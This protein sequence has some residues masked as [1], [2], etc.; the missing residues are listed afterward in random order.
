MYLKDSVTERKGETE[1]ETDLTS[2]DSQPSKG[3]ANWKPGAR[4]FIL[5]L[6]RVARVQILGPL[7]HCLPGHISREL[8][9]KQKSQNANQC[10]IRDAGVTSCD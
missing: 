8:D 3:W 7:Q 2:A 4:N 5:L 1:M 9:Q 6:H 10:L